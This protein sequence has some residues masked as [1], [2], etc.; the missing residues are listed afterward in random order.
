M[1]F[2]TERLYTRKL[3]KSDKDPFFDMMSNP[4]VMHPI[5]QKPMRL[6]ES[7]SKLLELIEMGSSTNRK[8]WAIIEKNN[9]DFIGLCGLIQNDENENEIAYRL[10]EKYW[11]I[12]YGTE[13]TKGLIDFGF[14]KLKFELITA[15]VNIINTRS[16]VILNKFFIPDKE[17][18]N[19]K[20]NCT[21]RR[22][23]L[24]KKDWLQ[25]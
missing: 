8:L 14:N 12:G 16:V 22:Y 9:L 21:D 3:E 17:F 4:E 2:K 7:Y 20:D 15:D 11:G 25:K 13:I 24:L 10:R 1:I 5:P 19:K 23:K 18:F 6:Q